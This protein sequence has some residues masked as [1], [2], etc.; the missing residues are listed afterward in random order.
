MHSIYL[1]IFLICVIHSMINCR[2]SLME[3]DLEIKY[4]LVQEKKIGKLIIS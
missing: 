2:S 4:W 3:K 1:L